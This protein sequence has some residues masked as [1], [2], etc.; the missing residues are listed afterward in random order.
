VVRTL[1]AELLVLGRLEANAESAGRRVDAVLASGHAA[2]HFGRMVAAMGGPA[3]FVER[4]GTILPAAPVVLTLESPQ[5]GWV[6]AVATREIGLAC[7]E[8]GGGR[9]KDSDRI[10]PRVGFTHVAAPGDR[11]EKGSPL[12]RVHAATEA[13]AEQAR[14]LLAGAFSLSAAAP[15]AAPVLVERIGLAA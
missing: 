5:D 12:A 7:I 8:L 10:D 4:A 9:H 2:D 14:M 6:Q 15:K 1:A 13:G 3:R 11:V